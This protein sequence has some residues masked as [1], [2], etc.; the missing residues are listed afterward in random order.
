MFSLKS[1]LYLCRAHS[2]DKIFRALL[3]KYAYR[4]IKLIWLFVFLGDIKYQVKGTVFIFF[5]P[6]ALYTYHRHIGAV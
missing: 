2:Y 4:N 6:A 3:R 1:Y 5:L